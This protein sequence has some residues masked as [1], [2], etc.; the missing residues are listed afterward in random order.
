MTG[1]CGVYTLA[2]NSWAAFAGHWQ[3]ARQIL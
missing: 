1:D 2:A 3:Y